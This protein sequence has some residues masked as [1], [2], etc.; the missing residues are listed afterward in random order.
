MSGVPS[1]PPSTEQ[2]HPASLAPCWWS[3]S[4]R[5]TRPAG[6]RGASARRGCTR[7]S[8]HTAPP[9]AIK[10]KDPQAIVLTGGPASVYAEG[11]PQLNP[12]CSTSGSRC[13][14]S[15]TR[16]QAMAQTLGGT[17]A[18]T[19]TSEY[20]RT[21]L[22]ISGGQLHSDLPGTQPVWM[23]RQLPP[24]PPRRRASRW[25]R[26]GGARSR[27]AGEPGARKVGVIA[28]DARRMA[29]RC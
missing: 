11:A 2:V 27:S 12:R 6:T 17:V 9:S 15:A 10:A 3:T 8:F 28:G 7:R 22:N 16:L 1:P 5:S 13:S 24:S 18:R 20:G 26:G 19:G 21:E 4:G 23:G 25:W 14:A 29:S